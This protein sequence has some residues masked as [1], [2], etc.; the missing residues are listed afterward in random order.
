MAALVVVKKYPNRRLYD[1]SESR[2]ITLEDLTARIR[3]GKNVQVL[4]AQTGADLTQATLTQI[5]LESRGG[6]RLLPVPL[7]VRLIRLDDEALAEFMGRY[8]SWALEM[9]LQAKRRARAF[10]PLN[11]LATAPFAAT[12]ALARLVLGAAQQ[13]RGNA[14]GGAGAAGQASAGGQDL[15]TE[16]PPPP[17]EVEPGPIDA[18]LELD[19]EAAAGPGDGMLDEVARLRRE[20]DALKEA[21]GAAPGGSP[22][23]P[24]LPAR[25]RPRAK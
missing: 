18:F 9:Y 8:V 7:L 2:Y 20:L 15:E 17:P 25:R 16:V 10:L 23:R 5:I 14:P 21:M 3:K 4:D 11:P 19:G 12:D 1:T 6:A 24:R 13:L 22:S